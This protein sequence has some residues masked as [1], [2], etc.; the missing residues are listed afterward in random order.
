LKVTDAWSLAPCEAPSGLAIDIVHHRLF[1]VCDND[2]MAVVDSVSGKV[3][4]TPAI[5]AGSDAVAYDAEHGL[6]FSSNGESGN[7]TILRQTTPDRYATLQTLPTRTGARTLAL[8]PSNDSVYTVT[9][10]LGPKPAATRAM[11]KPKPE[12]IPDTFVVLVV[13]R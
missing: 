12:I 5:G 9:A 1:S 11:P 13:R 10:K 7:L 4:D 8:D 6:V 2:K 3:V